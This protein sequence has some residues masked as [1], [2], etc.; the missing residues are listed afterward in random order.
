MKSF[1]QIVLKLHW[2]LSAQF[3]LD[4]RRLLL[5]IKGIV[6][7]LVDW[8]KFRKEYPGKISI[9]PCL[10][11][12]YMDAG[13]ATGEYFWQDLI[14]ARMVFENNPVKHV[15]VGSRIDGFVSHVAC[16]REIEVIDIRPVS[17]SVP[18][19]V[20]TQK[21]ISC[22]CEVIADEGYCDSLSCLHAL[23]HFGLGRYGDPLDSAGHLKGLK[24]LSKMLRFGGTLYLSCPVGAERVEF[25]ANR[26]L[27]PVD[28]ISA[29]KDCSLALKKFILYSEGDKLVEMGKNQLEELRSSRYNLGIFVFTK[30]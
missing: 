20:F 21:D 15:D 28:L 17:S 1:K 26:I 8:Y 10:H 12:R 29:A 16:Y 27:D 13:I 7:Y 3:G 6:P 5:A 14:V 22:D 30:E 11:D 9:V 4:L 25:N 19:I 2:I 18:G 23:E 24:N